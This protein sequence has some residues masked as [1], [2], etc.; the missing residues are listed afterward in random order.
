MP[1][2]NVPIGFPNSA[3]DRAIRSFAFSGS[4]IVFG[5]LGAFV[6]WSVFA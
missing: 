4:F 2:R 3:M 6:A 5:L 1:V